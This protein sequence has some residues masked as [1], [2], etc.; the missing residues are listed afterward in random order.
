MHAI[1][2][3]GFGTW[4]Q[5]AGFCDLKP[6]LARWVDPGLGW[7]SNHKNSGLQLARSNQGDLPSQPKTRVTR[8][9]PSETFFLINLKNIKLIYKYRVSHIFFIAYIHMNCFLT[10]RCGIAIYSLYLYGLF[11]NLLMWDSYKWLHPHRLFYNFLIWDN[12][13]TLH[14]FFV[15]YI[16]MN[17]FFM[18]RY[19]IIIY[20][21]HPHEL[22]LKFLMWDKYTTLHNFL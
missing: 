14:F 8:H 21:L 19:R 17:C 22:F 2:S 4:F 7:V 9:N 12:Y 13:I 3:K 16:H 10:F 15:A 1:G 18:F 20:S 11:L 6:G 5:C